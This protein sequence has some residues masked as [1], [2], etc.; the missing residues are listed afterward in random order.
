MK[1]EIGVMAGA[2]SKAFLVDLTKQLDR[3]EKLVGSLKSKAADTDETDDEEENDEIDTAALRKAATTTDDDEED[4]E[5]APKKKAAAATDDDEDEDSE[6]DFTAA[7]K[8]KQKKLTEKDVNDACKAYAKHI[9]GKKGR[10]AVLKIL[11]KFGTESVTDLD[12]KHYA[13][14]IKAL[15][16]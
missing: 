2:E 3:M 15:A 4:E 13:A 12:E 8:T 6:E 11:G 10:P 5:P 1:L 14:V 16:V 9:G 7:K